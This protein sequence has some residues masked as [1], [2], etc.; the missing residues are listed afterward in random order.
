MKD[1][2]YKAKKHLVT[3]EDA[4]Y[5]RF[6]NKLNKWSSMPILQ[7]HNKQDIVS[8]AKDD[9][10]SPCLHYSSS[11]SL[12]SATFNLLGTSK[13]ES[14]TKSNI[15]NYDSNELGY[16]VHLSDDELDSEKQDSQRVSSE[17]MQSSFI[18]LQ[19][20]E[21]TL[22]T[23]KIFESKEPVCEQLLNVS[24]LSFDE[25]DTNSLVNVLNTL[26]FNNESASNKTTSQEE[27]R[28]LKYRKENIIYPLKNNKD[29]FYARKDGATRKLEGSYLEA[30]SIK[31]EN[32]SEPEDT[33][34]ISSVNDSLSKEYLM[35]FKNRLKEIRKENL[36]IPV[37][38]KPFHNGNRF[39]K[40]FNYCFLMR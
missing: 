22:D 27:R 6:L 9:I 35:N 25:S 18:S 29:L 10:K 17:N 14:E 3:F 5:K 19:T 24:L 32:R 21:L 11:M 8:G 33:E 13:F 30:V 20:L 12:I 39:S 4:S 2:E 34:T 1:F 40:V 31:Q 15:E 37:P 23:C 38:N 26:K 36:T 16:L 7:I 28:E